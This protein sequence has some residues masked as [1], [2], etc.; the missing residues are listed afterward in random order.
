MSPNVEEIANTS[1]NVVFIKIDVEKN[2]DITDEFDVIPDVQD[3]QLP[4][5]VFMKNKQRIDEMYGEKNC[6]KLKGLV[7][8][9]GEHIKKKIGLVCNV[10]YLV[11]Y[12]VCK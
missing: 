7:E 10:R 8:K 9:H 12:E 11:T 4:V 6:S 5:F 1:P 3:P 2:R